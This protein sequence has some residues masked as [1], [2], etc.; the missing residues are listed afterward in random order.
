[1]IEPTVSPALLDDALPVIGVVLVAGPPVVFLAGPWLLLALT[2]SGPFALLVA[3]VVVGLVA[4]A[5]LVTPPRSSQRPTCSRAASPQLPRVSSAQRPRHAGRLS[6]LAARRRMIARAWLRGL[7]TSPD[8][9]GP[10]LPVDRVE[11]LSLF[12]ATVRD[13]EGMRLVPV[14]VAE[15]RP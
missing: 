1:M 14:T 4:A 6:P 7:A 15:A 9:I 13:F 10:A 2:L 11:T 3:F 8:A 12:Y 5:L